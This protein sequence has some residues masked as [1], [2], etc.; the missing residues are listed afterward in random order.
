MICQECG[1]LFPCKSKLDRHLN[2]KKSCTMRINTFNFIQRS[3]EKYPG[4]FLYDNTE[5]IKKDTKVK[6]FCIKHDEEFEVLPHNHLNKNGN[7]GCRKCSN[8]STMTYDELVNKL[9][10]VHGT[11]FIYDDE[12]KKSYKNSQS[13]LKICCPKHGYFTQP[14]RIHLKR[15]RCDK[16]DHEVLEEKHQIKISSLDKNR[17]NYVHPVYTNYSIN[18]QT[19]EVTN[20]KTKRISKG[21]VCMRGTIDF[22]LF[23]DDRNK[24]ISFHKFKYEAVHNEIIPDNFELDHR[25]QDPSDNSIENLQCLSKEEHAKK[26]ARDNPKRSEKVGKTQGISGSAY[27]PTT[28]IKVRFESV[29]DL[30]TKIKNSSSNIHRFLRTG[31]SPP[32]G[33]SEI[34]FDNVQ[35]IEGE[36][37]KPH[38]IFKFEISNMGRIK[39]R[40]RI[41]RGSL[42]AKQCYY[43]YSGH[44]VHNLVMD[45]WGTPKPSINHTVDHLNRDSKD[46]RIDNLRWADKSEQCLNK[47]NNILIKPR[48]INGYSGEVIELYDSLNDLNKNLKITSKTLHTSSSNKRD[49]FINLNP[50]FLNKERLRFVRSVLTYNNSKGIPG[51]TESNGTIFYLMKPTKFSHDRT[52][53]KKSRL[54]RFENAHH[55]M[56]T[57]AIENNNARIIQCYWRSYYNFMKNGLL[58]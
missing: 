11:T 21:S 5:Y 1:Y 44:K 47:R 51:L 20:I 50:L 13:I 14:M 29:N 53:Y 55:E 22:H 30:A 35:S 49:W 2:S 26:T 17:I 3:K 28:K 45:V 42:E 9:V 40:R 27:N 24:T 46:N 10:N 52:L 38:S 58:S 31:K 41:T 19:N 39:S 56:K 18:I 6:I 33:Y 36:Q 57:F 16:C 8:C 54:D 7:G 15:G 37:W 4:R 12:T 34:I 48:K 32:S 23:H 25:N 43:M